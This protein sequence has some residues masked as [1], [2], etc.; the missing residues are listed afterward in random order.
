MDN[1]ATTCSTQMCVAMRL[2]T[3]GELRM[4]T[5]SANASKSTA[6]LSVLKLHCLH[7]GTISTRIQAAYHPNQDTVQRVNICQQ[8]QELPAHVPASRA[9]DGSWQI[10]GAAQTR[11]IM[12]G[13]SPTMLPPPARIHTF[14][15]CTKHSVFQSTVIKVSC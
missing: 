12:Y 4:G 10:T 3:V 11:S 8:L 14:K 5:S 7:N 15:R 2:Y 1:T 9:H 6:N 13:I